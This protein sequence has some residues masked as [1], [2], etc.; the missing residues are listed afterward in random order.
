[1]ADILNIVIN[2]TAIS[3]LYAMVAIGFTLIFGVGGV[4]NLA[5]G[6]L[7][8]LGGFG[9]YMVANVWSQNIFV[10]VLA[11]VIVSAVCGAVIYLSVVRNLRNPIIIMIFT[12]VIGFFIQHTLRIF[13]TGA[14]ISTTS[15]V[16]GQT[17]MFGQEV[18]NNMIVIFVLSWIVIVALFILVN[19]TK[20]GK[21]ILAISMSQKGANLVGIDETRVNL[22][23]WLIGGGFA[24]LAGILLVSF[25]TG[26]WNMGIEPLIL[27]FAIV[28]LGGLGSIRGSVI[29]AYV[30]GFI[31]TITTS[32]ISPELT[33]V[34]ALVVL[35]AVLLIRPK[36]LFGRETADKAIA[37]GGF[38]L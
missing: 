19:R 24:G 14:R 6:G 33:G 20:T 28:I 26:G 17:T 13:I 22:Y 25:Q 4:F 3:A 30:V 32:L 29:G 27:S 5:H 7:I 35:F 11:G 23:T 1:M 18:Q 8:T 31:E 34:T 12:L 37:E 38:E 16:D 2:A 21:A 10:G 9:G 36:G 15:L